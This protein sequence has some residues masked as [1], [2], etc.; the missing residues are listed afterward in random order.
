MVFLSVKVDRLLTGEVVAKLF[1]ILNFATDCVQ[2]DCTAIHVPR[3]IVSKPHQNPSKILSSVFYI[4]GQFINI[5]TAWFRANGDI[6]QNFCALLQKVRA[7][8]MATSMH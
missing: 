7:S 6:P 1:I 8:L 5:Q 4:N 3:E 2:A